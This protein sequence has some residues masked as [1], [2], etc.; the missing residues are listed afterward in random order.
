MK[1]TLTGMLALATIVVGMSA[2]KSADV[3]AMSSVDSAAVKVDSMM[4][5]DSISRID[6]I[7]GLDSLMRIDSLTGIDSVMR[8]DSLSNIDSLTHVDSL[9]RMDSVSRVDSVKGLDSIRAAE[10]SIT[11]KVTPA[12]G[13]KEVEAESATG[14][15]K[16]S[17][18]QGTFTIPAAKAGNY[19]I[20]VLGKAPYKNAVIKDVKVEDGKATDLGEIKLEQ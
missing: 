17:I 13:A 15:L 19:T 8:I 12:D 18:A 7:S 3:K 11:G 10:G 16:G 2:F 1:R 4:R 20:T 14:K 6:S 9:F 5:V